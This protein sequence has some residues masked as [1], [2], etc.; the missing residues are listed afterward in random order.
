LRR[1]AGWRHHLVGQPTAVR[2]RKGGDRAVGVRHLERAAIRVVL[3]DRSGVAERID[4]LVQ[5]AL[6]V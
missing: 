3:I 5:V 2:V 1:S 6:A 4:D